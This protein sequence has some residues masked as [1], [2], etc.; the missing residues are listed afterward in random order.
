MRA[1]PLIMRWFESTASWIVS[2]GDR[3]TSTEHSPTSGTSPTNTISHANTTGTGNVNITPVT[4]FLSGRSHNPDG[5]LRRATETR[6]KGLAELVGR[7]NFFVELHAVFVRLLG[8]LGRMLG[9]LD[10]M[11]EPLDSGLREEVGK[12]GLEGGMN[13]MKLKTAGKEHAVHHQHRARG[14]SVDVGATSVSVSANII[15]T[16]SI[17]SNLIPD[18]HASRTRH[19]DA[20]LRQEFVA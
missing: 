12:V 1:L 14:E 3:E 4:S 11:A 19:L 9:G 20:S 15:P 18:I 5:F 10:A 13:A 16:P 2:M 6:A 8:Q 17:A 7:E